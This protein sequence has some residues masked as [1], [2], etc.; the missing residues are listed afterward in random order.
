M[1]HL[2]IILL[3]MLF[4]GYAGYLVWGLIREALAPRFEYVRFR[5]GILTLK[6]ISILKEEEIQIKPGANWESLSPKELASGADKID[7][8]LFP[9]GFQLKSK[10]PEMAAVSR[11]L[12]MASNTKLL[13]AELGSEVPSG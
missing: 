4:I 5:D 7:W 13:Q 11:C 2:L 1:T 12:R 8:Y 9:D 10:S 3:P 6:K